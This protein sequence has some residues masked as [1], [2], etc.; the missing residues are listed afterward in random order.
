LSNQAYSLFPNPNDGNLVL[1]QKVADTGLVRVD[2]HD[3]LG[4][5]VYAQQVRFNE[6]THQLQLKNVAPGVYVTIVT[7]SRGRKYTF[8]FVK[9]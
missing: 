5:S 9:Q 1:V 6:Q 3:V 8:K 7:D 4:R 2:V